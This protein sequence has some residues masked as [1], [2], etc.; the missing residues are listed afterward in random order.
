[1]KEVPYILTS[2]GTKLP[3]FKVINC[4]SGNEP[5]E[6]SCRRYYDGLKNKRLKKMSEAERI[7]VM[8]YFNPDGTVK[9]EYR[10]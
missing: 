6:V 4:I 1:M 9:K 3:L 2:G 10:S 8:G 5:F 7:R